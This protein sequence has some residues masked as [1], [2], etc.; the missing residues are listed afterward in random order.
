[1][2]DQNNGPLDISLDLNSTKTAIPM[3]ADGHLCEWRLKNLTQA[4]SD[5]GQT[6]K[7]EYDL[8]A[9]APSTEGTEIRPGD[10]GSKFFENIQLYAKP[11]AKDPQW[12]MKKLATRIDALLGTGDEGNSKGKPTRPALSAATVPDLLGKVLLA[13]MAVRT[14][15]YTGNE[16]KTVTF[17]GDVA[18]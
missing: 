13:K 11:D 6:L 1:M 15:E 5:K 7:F 17:P 10:M 2:A 12:F 18:A 4:S 3:I 16:F 9:P 14:G 8:V